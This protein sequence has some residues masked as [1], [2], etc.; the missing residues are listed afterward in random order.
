MTRVG[1]LLELQDTWARNRI[2]QNHEI[3]SVPT[4]SVVVPV[5]GCAGCLEQLC[6]QLETS[7]IGLTDRYEIILVDDRSP[8]DAWSQLASL[9]ARHPAVKG[10]RLSRNYGQ[11]IAIT[12]GLA[13]VRGDYAI[14]MDC[15]LQDPPGLIPELFAKLQEG[16]DLV[17]AKRVERSHSHFRLL[18]ARAYFK[19]LSNLTGEKIDGSYGTFS[20][21]SR[22]VIDGFLLFEEKE[23][24][25]LFIL[26]WLGFRIGSVDF[27]HQERHAGRSSYTLGRLI[28]HALNGILFQATVLLRWIVGLGF[29]FAFTGICLA[30]YFIWRHLTH[31]ALPGWTSLAVLILVSTGAILVSMGIIGLYVGKIFDQAKQRPLY[32]VDVVSESRQQW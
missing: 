26:R 22:K 7:L 2:W 32:V 8:D 18:A 29:L 19:L 1:E 10:I 24:H 27:V 6:Q 25:Y 21:L 16:Y 14:V 17:L 12:A 13:A 3:M 30:G 9:Q 4:L 31:T 5:Y 20:V 28:S 23:R 15:D 11:H